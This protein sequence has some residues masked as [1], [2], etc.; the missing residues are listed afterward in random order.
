MDDVIQIGTAAVAIYG[1]AFSTY[2]FLQQRKSEKPNLF[3]NYGWSYGIV[4]RK[5]SA[6]PE[7]L[8]LNAV[9]HGRRDLV[10]RHL[11]LE[12]PNFCLITPLFMKTEITNISDKNK[13][14]ITNTRLKSGDEVEISYDYN[15]LLFMLSNRG[16]QTPIRIR[17]VCEDSL[18]NFFFSTWFEIGE[19]RYNDGAGLD[20]GNR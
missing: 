5:M 2:T 10:V 19:C 14:D 1:A 8:N 4:D 3:V 9:N 20:S 13:Y 12:I 11:S 15:D 6:F 16:I 17:A 7:V 18:E